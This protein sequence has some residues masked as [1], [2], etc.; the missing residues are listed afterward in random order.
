MG[1]RLLAIGYGLLVVLAACFSERDATAPPAEG[2]CSLPVG[3]GVP[4]ST[5]VIVRAFTFTPAEVRVRPGDRVTWVN[6][7]PDPHTSTADGGQWSSPLLSSGDAFTHTFDAVGDFPY[8][9]EPHP[10][11]LARVI[12]E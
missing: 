10:F 7:D 4:G 12:V 5:L 9:C 11:M 6:C 1:N 3:E 2:V 8:H